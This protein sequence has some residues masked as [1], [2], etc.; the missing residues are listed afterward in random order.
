MFD[1]NALGRCQWSDDS[2]GGNGDDRVPDP[3]MPLQES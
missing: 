2:N 3:H 1:V